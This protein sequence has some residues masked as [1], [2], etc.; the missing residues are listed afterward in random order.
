[1]KK[2]IIITFLVVLFLSTL[3]YAGNEQRVGTAGA[4]VLLVNPWA[5]GSALGG[6]N[7]ASVQGLEGVFLN[8]AGTAFTRKTELIFTNSI[9]LSGA[10]INLNAFGFSQKVGEVGV[11][12]MSLINLNYGEIEKTTVSNP[13]GGI[14]FVNP[15]ENI[16][17]MSYAR[18]FSNSIYGGA[19][20][21]VINESI[22]NLNASGVAIDAGIIYLTGV[23]KDKAGNRQRDNL[24]FGISMKNV[25][26][27]MSFSGDGL[28][29]RGA[30][31]DNV[32]MTSEYP[33]SEFELPSLIAI[34]AS[35]RVY[36]TPKVDTAEGEV[37][38]A[39]IL[40]INANF[41]SNSFERDLIQFG[42]E[43]SFKEML[44]LRGGYVY[45]K[46]ALDTDVP[47][48]AY[49]GVTGGLGLSIPLNKEKGS[50]LSIEYAYRMTDYFDGTH[51]IGARISL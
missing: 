34:G 31:A 21:K 19:T 18:E 23:G 1:M 42:L 29:F 49:T 51:S 44:Y 25:G 7:T 38:S 45:R 36:L 46:G 24:R 12:S 35:Y 11:L 4:S 5:G 43:Y 28:S 17:S 32:Y 6:A 30:G 27:T 50:T 9:I 3:S 15:R 10:D 47:V 26:P 33:V 8:V 14:G 39:H 41:T 2:N 16:I 13:E 48:N 22:T 40:N 20:V 37:T